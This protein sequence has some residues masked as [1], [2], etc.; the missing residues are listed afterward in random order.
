[1]IETANLYAVMV[2]CAD[3]TMSLHGYDDSMHWM[4]NIHI[5]TWC[6]EETKEAADQTAAQVNAG[7]V[8]GTLAYV[9]RWDERFPK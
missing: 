3:G 4:R 1:M 7:C 6:S 2:R 9:R 8:R 5:I